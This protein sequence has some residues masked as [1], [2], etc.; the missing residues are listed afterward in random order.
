MGTRGTS[1]QDP[2]PFGIAS[3]WWGTDGAWH[4]ASDE[5]RHALR[6]ALGGDDHPDAP[7]ETPAQWIVRP[8][9]DR[10]VWSAGLLELDDGST[11]EV[12][13]ALPDDLPL[14][15]HTLTSE[16]GHV[17]RVFS[18]PGRCPPIA[19]SWGFSVQLPQT[20][21]SQSWGHGDLTDLSELA[22]WANGHGATVLAHNPLGATIPVRHQQPSPYYASSRRFLSPLYLRLESLPGAELLGDELTRAAAAGT[23]LNDDSFIDRDAVWAL[24][25]RALRDLWTKVR[26]AEHTRALLVAAR[27]D[28]ALVDHARFCALAEHHGGGWSQF[29]PEC[30]HPASAGTLAAAGALAN[31]VDR[32]IWTHVMI[33]EQLANACESGALLMADLPVGFDPDGSDAWVDQDLLALGCRIGAPPD[34]LGPLGQDWGLP[35]YVPWKLRAAGYRPWIETLRRIVAHAGMLRIDHVMGLFRLYLIP[36]GHDA[37]DGAYVYSY[38]AE[39]LDLACMEA[40]RA[41]A[42]LVGEDLGTV[43]PEVQTAMAERGVYGYQVGWFTDDAPSDWPDN[44]VA[45]L[46]THDLPTV[47]G[48]WTGADCAARA[49]AGLPEQTEADAVLRQRLEHLASIGGL[50]DP[51]SIPSG[52]AGAHEVSLTAHRA[53]AAAPSPLVIATLEDAVGQLSRPNLPGTV[54]EHPNWRVA[55]P[56]RIDDL[57]LSGAAEIAAALDRG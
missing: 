6:Q 37:L 49:A 55:L 5:T 17:T 50:D 29:P 35:P 42:S 9:A 44:K 53:I 16:G 48:M 24:K 22:R 15:S 36:P 2:D 33:E 43:E 40:V 21:S 26:D 56:S 52:L 23:A 25:S 8:G 4:H 31:D 57:D 14:G 12:H 51:A 34:D 41:G 18:V 45:M 3:G 1:A 54:D 39:L 27:N 7:P 47:A 28:A 13:R 19:R 46:S 32:W 38:G 30:R 20:R 11:I 10:G